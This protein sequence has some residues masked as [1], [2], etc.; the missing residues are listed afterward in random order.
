MSYQ[1]FYNSLDLYNFEL[2]FLNTFLENFALVNSLEDTVGLIKTLHL[3]NRFKPIFDTNQVTFSSTQNPWYAERTAIFPI[4]SDA[5]F[6]LEETGH[7]QLWRNNANQIKRARSI[8][9]LLEEVKKGQGLK[10]RFAVIANKSLHQILA[11]ST[12]YSSNGEQTIYVTAKS[13]LSIFILLLTFLSSSATVF[14]I[15]HI[16]SKCY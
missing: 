11:A 6:S 8:K 13:L 4:L 14:E 9:G 15:E 3:T 16:L 2:K 12:A 5:L 1:Q 7:L 10:G